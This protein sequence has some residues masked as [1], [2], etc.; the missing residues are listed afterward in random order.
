MVSFVYRYCSAVI[1]HA[2]GS[3]VADNIGRLLGD[4][5]WRAIKEH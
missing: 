3:C 2:A 1:L 5:F 4:W